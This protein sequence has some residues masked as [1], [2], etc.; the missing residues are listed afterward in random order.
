MVYHFNNW[1][2]QTT[3]TILDILSIYAVEGFFVISGIVLIYNYYEKFKLKQYI[4][5]RFF[6]IAPLFYLALVLEQLRHYTSSYFG[7]ENLSSFLI[8]MTNNVMFF[9]IF[10]PHRS[11]VVSGWS[12]MIEVGL[13]ILF[14]FL[15]IFFNKNNFKRIVFFVSFYAVITFVIF[16]FFIFNPSN[17][18]ENSIY[19]NIL[20][21]IPFFIFGMTIGYMKLFNIKFLPLW[22]LTLLL[23]ILILFLNIEDQLSLILNQNRVLLTIIT[24]LF[25]G[26]FT[27]NDI[28]STLSPALIK[29]VSFFS[30]LTYSIY[31]LHFFVFYIGF[32]LYHINNI[33]ILMIITI[34]V[35]IPTY[36]YYERLFIKL[37]RSYAR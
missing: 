15:L 24:I 10:Q 29:I 9:H 32:N 3:N 11:A 27:F 8:E 12:I 13:Y 34:L 14:P 36:Y 25:L 22:S 17:G 16:N 6:R 21:H 1:S 37:G 7:Y 4:I 31:L 28:L 5:H 23:F 33:Y 26:Y 30:N 18:F 35:S 2:G 19:T 20:F